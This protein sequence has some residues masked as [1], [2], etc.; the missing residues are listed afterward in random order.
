MKSLESNRF[1][2]HFLLGNNVIG[3]MGARAIADFVNRYAMSLACRHSGDTN[4]NT[5]ALPSEHSSQ[6]RTSIRWSDCKIDV[7]SE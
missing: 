1:I 3:P 4:R 5:I 6:T 2:R 7:P